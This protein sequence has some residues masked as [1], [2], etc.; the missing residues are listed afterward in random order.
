M[1]LGAARYLDGV[2]MLHVLVACSA[3]SRTSARA[4]LGDVPAV[5]RETADDLESDSWAAPHRGDVRAVVQLPAHLC[6]GAR[7][8]QLFYLQGWLAAGPD[9]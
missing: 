4:D 2:I 5:P 7:T 1:A 6:T 9:F 3:Y 8:M